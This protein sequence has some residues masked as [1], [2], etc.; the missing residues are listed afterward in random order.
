MSTRQPPHMP[1]PSTIIELR[2][3]TVL[4]PCGRVVSATACIIRSG[5]MASTKS[6]F[7]PDCDQLLELVG[8]EALAAV[9]AVVGRDQELVADRADLRLEDHQLLVPGP[10]DRDHVVAGFLHGPGRRV[11]DR[12]PDAAADHDH[13]A[14]VLDVR[15]LAQRSDEVEDRVAGVQHVE[16][17]RR[18]AD[19]LDDDL[20]RAPSPGRSRRWSGGSARRGCAAAR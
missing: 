8:H 7:R 2:L 13:G 3:T 14:V 1:V 12:R 5:P 16:Q 9:A 4:M 19:P 11:G 17:L 18:L 6:I 15:G 10:D 20:D